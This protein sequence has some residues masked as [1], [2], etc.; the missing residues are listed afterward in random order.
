MAEDIFY[1]FIDIPKS[2]KRQRTEDFEET[3][4]SELSSST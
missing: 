1:T 3:R 2:K 4:L